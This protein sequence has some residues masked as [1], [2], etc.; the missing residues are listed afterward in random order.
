[1]DP[2]NCI[3]FK[4]SGTGNGFISGTI[5]HLNG[6]ISGQSNL[7]KLTFSEA[8]SL[9]NSPDLFLETEIYKMV[10]SSVMPCTLIVQTYSSL[11]E[12]EN[13]GGEIIKLMIF[14]SSTANISIQRLSALNTIPFYWKVI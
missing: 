13:R 14:Y 4:I 11:M 12:V 6:A 3:I 9:Q 1:M 2:K 8:I 10:N 5:N 7:Q